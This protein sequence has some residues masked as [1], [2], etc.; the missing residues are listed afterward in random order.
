VPSPFRLEFLAP[1][2]FTWP[3]AST[4]FLYALTDPRP[5]D[6]HVYVGKADDPRR[7]FLEH[8]WE[9]PGDRSRKA[10]WLRQLL[11]LGLKPTQEILREVPFEEWEH[12]E[13]EFIRWYRVLGWRVVNSTDGGDGAV[14][15]TPEARARCAAGRRGK[16]HTPEARAAIGAAARGRKMSAEA[17]AKIAAYRR[18]EK[19]SGRKRTLSAEHRANIGLGN[20][21]R[22]LTDAQKQRMRG[23]KHALGFRHTPEAR[24]AISAASKKKKL[25]PAH[26]AALTAGRLKKKLTPAPASALVHSLP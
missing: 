16:G 4:T 15:L 14:N 18:R 13:R 20:R 1:F 26:I 19:E 11:A 22:K 7:R 24:A 21:G 5:G 3:I 6:T 25:S 9:L 12:W 2:C 10:H 23:N 17:R 8:Y